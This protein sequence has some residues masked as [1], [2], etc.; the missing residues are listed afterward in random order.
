MSCMRCV[1]HQID[2][3]TRID[4]KQKLYE[5][6]NKLKSDTID[7]INNFEQ[8]ETL[9]KEYLEQIATITDDY[10]K[11]IDINQKIKKRR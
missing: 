1:R 10:N 5:V 6:I 9:K 4:N 3:L 2:L 11:I 8:D 7:K